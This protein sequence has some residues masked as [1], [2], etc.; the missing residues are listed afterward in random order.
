[1]RCAGS[2]SFY[3]IW[4]KKGADHPSKRQNMV[5]FLIYSLSL[6]DCCSH[7]LC[8][9]ACA[10][11]TALAAQALK[12]LAALFL[13]YSQAQQ[14]LAP[15]G[16]D[17]HTHLARCIHLFILWISRVLSCLSSSC[18]SSLLCVPCL[19]FG[20]GWV[21]P[22]I[23]SVLFC[24]MSCISLLCFLVLQCLSVAVVISCLILGDLLLVTVNYNHTAKD[25]DRCWKWC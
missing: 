21:F 25:D 3:V 18:P 11:V 20:T 2:L 1:M 9:S 10:S 6:N 7:W 14:G 12:L 15:L 17:P 4:G 23:L 8:I 24:F 16:S 19:I 13:P 5:L 22:R